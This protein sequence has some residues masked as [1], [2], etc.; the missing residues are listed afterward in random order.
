MIG[1]RC[2]ECLELPA[3]DGADLCP[4][5]ALDLRLREAFDAGVRRGYAQ[6]L[7]DHGLVGRADEDPR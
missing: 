4:A 6:A 7:Q 1:R 5:C 2:L 3:A